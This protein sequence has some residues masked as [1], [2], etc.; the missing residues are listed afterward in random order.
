MIVEFQ[1]KQKTTNITNEHISTVHSIEY[2]HL[3]LRLATRGGGDDRVAMFGVG[4]LEITA[5]EP[6][7]LVLDGHGGSIAL[8]SA[9]TAWVARWLTLEGV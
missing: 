1:R 3:L 2:R 9:S 5:Q 4:V 8:S 6:L 7:L